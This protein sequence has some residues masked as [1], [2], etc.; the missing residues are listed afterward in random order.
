[1]L[2]FPHYPWLKYRGTVI[3]LTW[4]EELASITRLFH[5]Q[6]SGFYA[7]R[8]GNEKRMSED[9]EPNAR[10]RPTTIGEKRLTSEE[11]PD[12]PTIGTDLFENS[13]RPPE[14]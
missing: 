9:T 3:I 4:G 11:F 6:P 1:M 12:I 8:P 2:N 14:I 7:N 10:N 5:R 13:D